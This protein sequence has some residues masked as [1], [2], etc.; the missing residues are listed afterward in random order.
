LYYKVV[1][2]CILK[3]TY[4]FNITTG[5][6]HLK[7]MPSCFA[8]FCKIHTCWTQFLQKNLC[9]EF[10]DNP[11][12]SL[13]GNTTQ[14][15]GQTVSHSQFHALQ[16]N[17]DNSNQRI[18]IRTNSVST[19][20]VLLLCNKLL[21]SDL[22]W[23]I[24]VTSCLFVIFVDI[25]GKCRFSFLLLLCHVSDTYNPLPHQNFSCT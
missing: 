10:H 6:N 12:N 5:M 17:Y 15:K 2:D 14:Q 19:Q 23:S 18:V 9:S 21:K 22:Y 25:S 20:A 24:K 3:N 4:L 1:Y 8:D 13:V 11:V 7:I 16:F